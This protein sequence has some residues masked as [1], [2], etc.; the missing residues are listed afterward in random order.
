MINTYTELKDIV[1]NYSLAVAY[2]Y[3]RLKKEEG[4]NGI[5]T[6]EELIEAFKAEGFKSNADLWDRV[7][8]ECLDNHFEAVR[9]NGGTLFLEEIYEKPTTSINVDN[10]DDEIPF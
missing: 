3:L 2:R 10:V 1:E 8:E 6:P 9:W 5:F 7:K 4:I